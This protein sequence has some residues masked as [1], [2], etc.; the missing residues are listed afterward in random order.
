[1][2]S[3]FDFPAVMFQ[4]M[5]ESPGVKWHDPCVGRYPVFTYDIF[6]IASLKIDSKIF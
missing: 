4:V 2:A 1:M 3:D 5:T 6:V